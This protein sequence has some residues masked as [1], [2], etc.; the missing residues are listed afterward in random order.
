MEWAPILDGDLAERGWRIVRTVADALARADEPPADLA[1][2]WAYAAAALEDPDSAAR[3]A[4]ACEQFAASLRRPQHGIGIIDGLAHTGWVAAQ[5][6]DGADDALAE[7][8]RV[9]LD[10]LGAPWTRNYDLINGLVGLAVYFLA[11][12]HD[13]A[14]ARI[15]EHLEA[16]AER[17]PTG[18]TWHTPAAWNL[19]VDLHPDGHYNCGL[20][21][22]VPGV[23]SVLSKIAARGHAAA[24]ALR[25]DALRWLRAQIDGVSVPSFAGGHPARTAWCYGAPGV[26]LALWHAGDT[27]SPIVSGWLPRPGTHVVDTGFCH[28]AAGLAHIANR[29]FHA[30]GDPRYR[31]AARA[32][33][34]WTLDQHRPGE[35]IGGFVMAS[36]APPARIDL[37]DGTIGVGLVLLAG[38]TPIEPAWDSMFLC[39]L[40]QPRS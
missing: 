1:L 38:L 37:L 25:D 30:S 39:D 28:G 5:L 6:V 29:M 10:V 3:A 31:D 13:P 12:E 18:T 23:I 22:G 24:A 7:I 14:L 26:A 9:L 27:T 21:H 11:R 19:N 20:A 33:L 15:V 34:A 16:T 36:P 32:W 40:P 2:F 35:G 17:T 4:V 8:D